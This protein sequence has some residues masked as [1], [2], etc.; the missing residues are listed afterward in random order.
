[1]KEKDDASEDASKCARRR[2]WRD[3]SWE[4]GGKQSSEGADI[5]PLGSRT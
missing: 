3:E 2:V 1:M 5:L 4:G